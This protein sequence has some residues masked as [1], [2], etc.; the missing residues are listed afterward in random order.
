MIKKKNT[1][2]KIQKNK[3]PRNKLILWLY[4]IAWAM[5]IIAAVILIYGIMKSL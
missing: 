4:Y 1:G 2:V 5:G 3:N